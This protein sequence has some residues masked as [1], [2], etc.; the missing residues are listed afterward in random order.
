MCWIHDWPAAP[1]R[2]RVVELRKEFGLG[3]NV[4]LQPIVPDREIGRISYDPQYSVASKAAEGNL[5]LLLYRTQP[6]S[7]IKEIFK[8]A[9]PVDYVRA[10][11]KRGK[12]WM[13]PIRLVCRLKAPLHLRELQENP[14]VRHAGF[15]RGS[16]QGRYKAS[17]YWPELY[18]MILERNPSAKRALAKFGP[19]RLW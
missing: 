1:S 16:M 6:D 17:E 8:V 5:L 4:W 3:F 14:I 15:V 11:W 12:D 2:I 13:A 7:F 9:G 18:R 10:G 19:D